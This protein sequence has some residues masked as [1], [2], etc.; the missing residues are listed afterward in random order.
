[1]YGISLLKMNVGEWY[2]LLILFYSD[3]INKFNITYIYVDIKTN[4]RC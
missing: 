1:M 4:V 3:K 2:F